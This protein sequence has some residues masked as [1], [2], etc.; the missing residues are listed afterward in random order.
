MDEEGKVI[1]GDEHIGMEEYLDDTDT[2]NRPKYDPITI[3]DYN[4]RT[5]SIYL[6]D[7]IYKDKNNLYEYKKTLKFSST[8][9]E[10]V[11]ILRDCYDNEVWI[12]D[13]KKLMLVI[14][15]DDMWEYHNAIKDTFKSGNKRPDT[16]R[17]YYSVDIKKNKSSSEEWEYLNELKM[18]I[19]KAKVWDNFSE[20][21][22]LYLDK[23]KWE[24]I[25]KHYEEKGK[26]IGIK[27]I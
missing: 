25:N 6:E 4:S 15:K 16:G 9:S 19:K 1:K 8:N 11:K 17:R 7:T 18:K 23:K 22:S 26:Y 27:H 13:G 5:D 2:H 3:I 14:N 20:L 10:I 24:K 12:S 21:K